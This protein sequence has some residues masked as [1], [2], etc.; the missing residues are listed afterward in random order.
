MGYCHGTI[1]REAL[2]YR[3]KVTRILKVYCPIHTALFSSRVTTPAAKKNRMGA[4]RLSLGW[5][6]RIPTRVQNRRHPPFELYKSSTW[7]ERSSW[8]V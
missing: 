1:S 3:A 2:L 7:A 6:H 5:M 4:S 8:Y